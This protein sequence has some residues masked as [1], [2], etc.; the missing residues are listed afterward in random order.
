VIDPTT[1]SENARQFGATRKAPP[2]ESADMADEAA[3]CFETD[4]VALANPLR[5]DETFADEL[6]RA[7]CNP[8]WRRDDG[9]ERS[10]S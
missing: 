6:Y 3:R 4:L 1:T 7:P 5:D 2:W 8:D 9:S 10:G